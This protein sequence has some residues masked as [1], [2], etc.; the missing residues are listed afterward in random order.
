M[1]NKVFLCLCG[2][3]TGL[4]YVIAGIQYWMPDYLKA[5]LGLS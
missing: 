4:Y 3:L 2:T 5:I 1:A